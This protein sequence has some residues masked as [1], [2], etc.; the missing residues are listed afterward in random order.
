MK[1]AMKGGDRPTVSALRL[2]LSAVHYEEIKQRGELSA[3]EILRTIATLCKQRQ[4]AIEYFSKGGRA[5]LLRQ[6]EAEL[7]ALRRFLPE[8]LGEE[9]VRALIRGSIEEVG[10]KGL[11]DLGSVMKRLMPKVAGR[12]EGKRVSELVKEML[13]GA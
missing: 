4:E 7:A 5:D 2:L 12:S 11:Q 9:E 6:E 8:A 10:A 3:D 13:R 1:A